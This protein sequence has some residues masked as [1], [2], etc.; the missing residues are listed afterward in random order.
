MAAIEPCRTL[1][2]GDQPVPVHAPMAR[3]TRLTISVGVAL[4]TPDTDFSVAVL[5]GRPPALCRQGARPQ[6][7]R[8]AGHS[9]RRLS[10]RRIAMHLCEKTRTTPAYFA[11][12]AA[13]PSSPD[14]HPVLAICPGRAGA[15]RFHSRP[16]RVRLRACRR[17]GDQRRAR[18]A[19]RPSPSWRWRMSRPPCRYLPPAFRRCDWSTVSARGVRRPLPRCP[20]API[21][22]AHSDPVVLRWG[23]SATVLLMLALLMSGWRYRGAPR[24]PVSDSGRGDR[25]T[26]L[27]RRRHSRPAD[28]HL[29]DVGPGRKIGPARQSDQLFRLLPASAASWPIP[30][31]ACSPRR[32]SSRPSS[33]MPVYGF[34]TWLGA[35]AHPH[36]PEARVPGHRLRIDR[37]VGDYRP[38]GARSDP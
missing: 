6:P 2:R 36:T 35:R 4:A 1:P 25:R 28:R 14:Y 33:P 20:S 21:I 16:D 31:P 11:R 23:L 29:L 7:H 5:A 37:P 13:V 19:S 17:S 9:L 26:V 15:C 3:T 27:G 8:I 10:G 18:P 38:A 24:A 34:A 32:S 22:L 12:T 30:S